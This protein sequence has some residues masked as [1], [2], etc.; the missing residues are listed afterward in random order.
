MVF[1][2]ISALEKAAGSRGVHE[3]VRRAVKLDNQA[4]RSAHFNISILQ[5]DI[6]DV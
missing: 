5:V 2:E 6:L 1:S 3:E 4:T